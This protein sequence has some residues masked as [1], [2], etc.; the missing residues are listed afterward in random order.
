MG[1]HQHQQFNLNYENLRA[2]QIHFSKPKGVTGDPFIRSVLG[3]LKASVNTLL[4]TV[5]LDSKDTFGT[6]KYVF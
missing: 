1:E 6:L 3:K 5:K 2:M 4:F